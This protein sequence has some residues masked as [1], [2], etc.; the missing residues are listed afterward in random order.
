MYLSNTDI[1]RELKK[2]SLKIAPFD[3]KNLKQASY[4]LALSNEFYVP[5]RM[6]GPID[7][8]ESTDP[9]KC[10]KKVVAKSLELP[11][12]GFCLALTEERITMPND[13]IGILGGRSR[14][15]RLGMTVHVTSAVIQP[16]SDN[17]Q[18]L[19]IA[20]LSPFTLKLYA[21]ERVSQ[22]YFERLETPTS[23][24]Y[25]KFGRIAVRQ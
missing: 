25:K 13:L 14:F 16:G 3:E 22:V 23:K 10:M 19:E 4:D 1:L 8:R 20:N 2:G 15:A 7:V 18:V 24:P 9:H 6:R 5:R 12:G 17:R 11:P 21:G